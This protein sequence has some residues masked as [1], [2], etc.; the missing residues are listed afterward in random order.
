MR[1]LYYGNSA[2]QLL[3]ILNLHHQRQQGF[4]SIPDYEADLILQD[5]FKEAESLCE[6]IRERGLFRSVRCTGKKQN[7]GGLHFLSSLSDIVFP[8]RYLKKYFGISDVKNAY[9][10]IMVPKFMPLIAAIW[11]LNS[12]AEL[13][14]HEDGAGSYFSYFDLEM[15]S[16]SY[17]TFYKAFNHGKDFYDFKKIYLNEPELYFREDKDRVTAIPPYE[18]SFLNEVKEMFRDYV[19]KYPESIDVY[20]LSQNLS[21]RKGKESFDCEEALELL[22]EYPENVLYCPHPRNPENDTIFMGSDP[23]QIWEM[24]V[25]CTSDIENKLII[26]VHSTACLTPK[27]LFDKEPY[28]I[29]L[30]RMVIKHDW[31]YY[32]MMEKVVD[33]FV[34]KH[35]DPDKVMRPETIEEYEGCLKRFF[36]SK[37]KGI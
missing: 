29:L 35:R 14:L 12:K 18:E 10:A 16:K 4:E 28:V 13:H 24:Q 20:W 2:Y 22:K 8:S 15:R 37:K 34:E 23:R 21:S 19:V 9:D 33:A 5:S 30:Y 26:S 17:K 3:N 36:A 7:T 25:L 31:K 1:Y 27:I 6:I 32:A 11:Q